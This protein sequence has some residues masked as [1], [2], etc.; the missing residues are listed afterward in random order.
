M[1]DIEKKIEDILWEK[2]AE[3]ERKLW[4]EKFGTEPPLSA[5]KTKKKKPES[6]AN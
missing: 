3:Q 5:Q 1:N 4:K 2:I 6:P